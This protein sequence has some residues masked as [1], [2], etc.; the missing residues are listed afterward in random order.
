MWS[1]KYSWNWGCRCCHSD[2]TYTPHDFWEI[3]NYSLDFETVSSSSS[4]SSTSESGDT[5]DIEAPIWFNVEINGFASITNADDEYRTTQPIIALS[6]GSQ[7]VAV[8]FTS[9]GLSFYPPCGQDLA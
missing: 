5:A 4:S 3:Y 2:T 1:P 6:D 9:N 8:H 7:F